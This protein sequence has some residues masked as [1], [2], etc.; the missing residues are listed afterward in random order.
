MNKSTVKN[1]IKEQY[2]KYTEWEMYGNFLFTL[3]LP[4]WA[5]PTEEMHLDSC[6]NPWSWSGAVTALSPSIWRD[7]LKRELKKF[8]LMLTAVVIPVCFLSQQY[9]YHLRAYYK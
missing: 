5:G 2:D 7:A 8:G 3:V 9:Q 1:R 6:T 4:L